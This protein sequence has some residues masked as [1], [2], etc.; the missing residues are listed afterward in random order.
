MWRLLVASLRKGAATTPLAI[1]ARVR[2]RGLATAQA[3]N[4]AV[5]L[6]RNRLQPPVESFAQLQ[7][8][9][10]RARCSTTSATA[11]ELC[12]R[13]PVRAEAPLATRPGD[14]PEHWPKRQP[15]RLL[16]GA[17]SPVPA[18]TASARRGSLSPRQGSRC[19]RCDPAARPDSSRRARLQLPESGGLREGRRS[20]AASGSRVSG[21]DRLSP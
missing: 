21:R 18:A 10:S 3:Q 6:G 17:A 2:P 15:S 14:I 19:P 7:F 20:C 4:V 16:R 5:Q 8:A 1:L 11:H 9:A 12:P 13:R